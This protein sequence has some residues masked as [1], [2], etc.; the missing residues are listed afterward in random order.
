M[1]S[2]EWFDL[3]ELFI[4]CIR[5]EGTWCCIVVIIIAILSIV[6]YFNNKYIKNLLHSKNKGLIKNKSMLFF[7]IPWALS[8]FMLGIDKCGFLEHN[9]GGV[10]ILCVLLFFVDFIGLLVGSIMTIKDTHL[11]FIIA[12]PAR[13]SITF[14]LYII[15]AIFIYA[16]LYLLGALILIVIIGGLFAEDIIESIKSW[17][18]DISKKY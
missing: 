4:K 2:D 5:K 1:G 18:E 16:F 6:L 8:G 10:G 14:L 3:M 13:I 9:E 7:G 12:I 11:Y 15:C 17:I